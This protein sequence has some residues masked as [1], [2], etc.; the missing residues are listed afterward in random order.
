MP[1]FIVQIQALFN[2]EEI[3]ERIVD[4]A[5]PRWPEPRKASRSLSLKAVFWCA[6][7]I[8]FSLGIGNLT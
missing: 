4:R 8:L 2:P 7:A 3:A 5:A 6:A 1:S